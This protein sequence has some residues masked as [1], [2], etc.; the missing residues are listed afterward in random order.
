MDNLLNDLKEI[1]ETKK[2]LPIPLDKGINDFIEY[3][4]NNKRDGTIECYKDHLK[5]FKCFMEQ[6]K[7]ETLNVIN[8]EIINN[9]IN[10]LKARGVTFATINKK[11]GILNILYRYYVSIGALG[12]VP[13][14]F[15]KLHETPKPLETV[16]EDDFLK[17][18]Q[19]ASKQPIRQRTI[20]YLLATTG[21]RTNELVHIKVKNCDLKEK[22]IFLEFT[23]SGQP[24]YIYLVKSVCLMVKKLIEGRLFS[25]YLFEDDHGK[26]I[27]SEY[28]TNLFHYVRLYTDIKVI[29]PHRL[30]HTYGTYLLK[31]GANLE[32]V[33]R[34]LGHSDFTMTKRY[35]DYLDTDLAAA[36]SKFNPLKLLSKG[37]V[38]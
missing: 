35:I 33:R 27:T 17:F 19:Y 7:L 23:K 25:V 16:C 24:R 1:I 2:Y 5:T 15:K 18:I 21:I 22:R 12:C 3:S 37:G 9:Y 36:N 20:F 38:K 6:R 4:R 34:L 28:V 26:P 31:N 8:Q 14:Q 30:R 11:I 32:E 10:I 29:S 13:F